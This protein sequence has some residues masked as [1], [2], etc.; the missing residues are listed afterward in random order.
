MLHKMVNKNNFL[1]KKSKIANI[2]N[3]NLKGFNQ[4]I[5]LSFLG[6][7]YLTKLNLN[8]LFKTEWR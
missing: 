6:D 7:G 2:T 5:R 3:N 8:R 4:L 1:R